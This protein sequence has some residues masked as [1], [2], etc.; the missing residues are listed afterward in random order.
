VSREALRVYARIPKSGGPGRSFDV[1]HVTDSVDG[2]YGTSSFSPA[3][4]GRAVPFGG[5]PQGA[6]LAVNVQLALAGKL[7]QDLAAE[8]PALSRD[9]LDLLQ[10]L[11]VA[12]L[13]DRAPAPRLGHVAL[14][15][16]HADRVE[17]GLVRLVDAAPAL[18]AAQL[19]RLTGPAPIARLEARWASDPLDARGQRSLDALSRSG[20]THD[21]PLF[22]PLLRGMRIEPAAHRAERFYVEHPL[23]PLD[24]AAPE[25]PAEFAVLSQD[26]RLDAVEIVA[27]ASAPGFVRL[28]YGFD[29]ALGV[30]LDG[31]AAPSVPDFLGAV[32]LA[33]PAGTHAIT[34]AAPPATLRLR[35]LAASGALAATLL[36]VW[37]ASFL[38]ESRP[39]RAELP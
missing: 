18:F 1:T 34:L 8:P 23:P 11:H 39:T 25:V 37:A 24:A 33:F 5:F 35:L 17:P 26:E 7:V 36:L 14:D 3:W 31:R 2:I 10:L 13:V 6:P 15:A 4:T 21:W 19:E 29:P 32:V 28:A 38:P 30:A 12:W 27:R 20:R 9:A 16:R 22:L